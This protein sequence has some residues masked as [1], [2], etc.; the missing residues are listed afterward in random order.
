VTRKV[1]SSA[2]SLVP[3][4]EESLHAQMHRLQK[5]VLQTESRL[6]SA[7]QIESF[8]LTLDEI[9]QL[10]SS[11]AEGLEQIRQHLREDVS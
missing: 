11:I 5:I 6:S 8:S 10:K 7:E 3:A 9:Q 1:R 4:I 2:K